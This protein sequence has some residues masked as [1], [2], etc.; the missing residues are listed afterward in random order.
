MREEMLV[1]ASGLAELATR[2]CSQDDPVGAIVLERLSS[3]VSPSAK[4][5]IF[6]VARAVRSSAHFIRKAMEEEALSLRKCCSVQGGHGGPAALTAL[7]RGINGEDGQ[8]GQARV[9][10]V[11]SRQDL[12]PC[13]PIAHPIQCQMLLD[14]SRA[15]FYFGNEK[16]LRLAQKCLEMCLMKTGFYM[17]LEGA[18]LEAHLDLFEAQRT[19]LGIRSGGEAMESFREIDQVGRSLLFQLTNTSLDYYCR[20]SNWVPRSAVGTLESQS[21]KALR[22][23][24]RIEKLYIAYAKAVEELQQDVSQRQEV[25][26]EVDTSQ[27]MIDVHVEEM[28]LVLEKL[29]RS[30]KNPQINLDIERMTQEVTP[31]LEDLSHEVFTTFKLTPTQLCDAVKAIAAEPSKSTAAKEVG[32]LAWQGFTKVP[33]VDGVLV[34]KDL[35]FSKLE[36]VNGNLRDN[37][38]KLMEGA[39]LSEDGFLVGDD[40]ASALVVANTQQ[41]EDLLAEFGGDCFGGKATVAATKLRQ[42]VKVI[43]DRNANIVQYNVVLKEIIDSR[44]RRMALEDRRLSAQGE[45]FKGQ[46]LDQISSMNN[47]TADIHN[48]SRQRSM[49]LLTLYRRAVF[50]STL[51]DPD[52]LAVGGLQN[53]AALNLSATK[54]EDIKNRLHDQLEELR[55]KKGSD[56]PRYPADYE[57]A[58]GKF[59]N[60]TSLQLQELLQYGRLRVTLPA[61]RRGSKLYPD[62]NGRADVRVYRARFW[63][64]GITIRDK[65]T[66]TEEEKQG[67]DVPVNI[68]MK[69]CGDSQFTDVYN[70]PVSFSHDEITVTWQYR[71][72]YKAASATDP[73]VQVPRPQA[74]DSGDFVNYSAMYKD[75]NDAYAAPSPFATWVVSLEH[76]DPRLD[77]TNVTRGRF[78]FF[79]TSRAFA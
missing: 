50:F 76:L 53:D 27:T 29:R 8:A 14:K 48:Y 49:R 9:E 17:S 16:S 71:I 58:P 55:E 2:I 78:E 3:L 75:N 62:F 57:N 32:K 59:I 18:D 12:H 31:L 23:L 11:C 22:D 21:E 30:I 13:F 68:G 63:L 61:V 74:V 10:L 40:A 45:A 33:N 79:G 36:T 20:R 43:G 60:L 38:P 56:A 39:K 1:Q 34:D 73:T 24:K 44:A 28:R 65:S 52:L 67:D 4:V 51:S 70:E 66:W 35:L 42:Y 15:Y 5:T 41:I 26:Q 77:L 64:E 7:G 19:A 72:Y 37:L 25:I 46:D 47:L 69:H 54:L 6:D